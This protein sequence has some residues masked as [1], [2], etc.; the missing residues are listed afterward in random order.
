MTETFLAAILGMIVA[1]AS[2]GPNLMAVASVA[3]RQG[4]WPGLFVVFGVASGIM[5]WVVLCA[6]GVV[7]LMA[8]YPEVGIAMRFLGGGY[9]L[10]LG[11]RAIRAAIANRPATIKASGRDHSLFS[12][13]RLG[14]LVVL[15]NPKAMLMWLA[16]SAFVFSAGVTPVQFLLFIPIG[17][18]TAIAIYGGYAILFSTGA[19]QAI[20]SR[21]ARWFEAAFGAV[22]GALGARLIADGIR[23]ARP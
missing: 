7:G 21:F 13:W 12:A 6:T 9:L 14:A 22:F 15:T 23:E 2:P 10:W 4:R 5:V 16:V 18:L 3:L 11:V 8:T 17:S 1:Q 20:F 19:A